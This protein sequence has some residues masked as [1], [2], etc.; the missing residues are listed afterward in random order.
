MSYKAID[1]ANLYI[2]LANG[3]EN[4]QMDNLKLNKLCYYAQAWSLIKLGYPIFD[5]TI[6]AWKYGPVIPEVYRTYSVCG[7]RPIAEPSFVFDES[8][9]SS[10]ELSLLVDVYMT[11]SQYTSRALIDRT[12]RQCEPWSKVYVEGC[13]MPISNDLIISCFSGSKELESMQLDLS[14]ENV[15]TYD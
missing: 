3:L 8:K 12:H 10:D 7:N 5:D 13:N 15:V 6:E 1:I 9:L 2:A 4:E 11:Y 14:P